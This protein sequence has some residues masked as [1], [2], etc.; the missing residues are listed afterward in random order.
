[1]RKLFEIGLIVVALIFGSA[2]LTLAD[3]QTGLKAYRSGDYATALRKWRPLAEL[4]DANAQFNLGLLFLQGRGVAQD[5]KEA[6]MWFRKST[7]Q[8]NANAQ[9]DPGSFKE[10]RCRTEYLWTVSSII[11]LLDTI[12]IGYKLSVRQEN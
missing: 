7:E 12:I 8:G 5:D 4:G 1:M 3:N 10:I 11:H 2:A 6:M 9:F